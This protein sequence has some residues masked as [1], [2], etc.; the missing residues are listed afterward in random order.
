[1][2]CAY[3]AH[4]EAVEK[5]YESHQQIHCLTHVYLG[6]EYGRD[7]IEDAIAN[8]PELDDRFEI[9]RDVDN[10][11]LAIRLEEGNILGLMRGRMEFGLR[12][13]GNRSILADPS[14]ASA[15][16]KI[17][18]MIKFRDFWMPFTPSTLDDRV[19]GLHR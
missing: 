7:E 19:A 10:A 1:M 14:N 3:Q 12:S 4:Y 15:T 6:P 9:H 16:D 13:L 11:A 5:S 2:G 17:N 8:E 18:Q